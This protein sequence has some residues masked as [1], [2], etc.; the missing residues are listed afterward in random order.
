MHIIIITKNYAYLLIAI[1]VQDKECRI[2]ST[3][4]DQINSY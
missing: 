1:I 2:K 3:D 4:K